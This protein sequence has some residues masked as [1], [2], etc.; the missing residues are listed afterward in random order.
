MLLLRH[1][2]ALIQLLSILDDDVLLELGMTAR[3]VDALDDVYDMSL[4]H[5]EN[6]VGEPHSLDNPS[7]DDDDNTPTIVVIHPGGS[8]Q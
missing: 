7:L 8:I 2:K 5:Y 6:V 3:E 4:G 1:T